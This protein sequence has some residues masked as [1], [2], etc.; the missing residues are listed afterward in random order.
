MK[1]LSIKRSLFSIACGIMIAFSSF[2]FAILLYTNH[3][4]LQYIALAFTYFVGIF[5]VK[6]RNHM[7]F[8]QLAY[9]KKS[10]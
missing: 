6:M 8:N 10:S 7:L 5:Y 2:G 1:K 3:A 9:Q 4:V